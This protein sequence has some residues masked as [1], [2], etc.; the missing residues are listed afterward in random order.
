MEEEERGW[1]A[2][3]IMWRDRC[4]EDKGERRTKENGGEG[5]E[6]RGGVGVP[7]LHLV[8]PAEDALRGPLG[9]LA[10]VVLEL[11]GLTGSEGGVVRGAEGEVLGRRR[12][13]NGRGVGGL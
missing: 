6:R 13:Q 9:Q 5:G 7:E 3:A 8:G 4:I 1:S 10:R 12:Q 2:T 11:R